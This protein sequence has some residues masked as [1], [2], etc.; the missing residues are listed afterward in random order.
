MYQKNSGERA[1]ATRSE[2]DYG[3]R[4]EGCEGEGD[5][6]RRIRGRP[7]FLAKADSSSERASTKIHSP[8][9]DSSKRVFMLQG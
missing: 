6:K 4:K 9:I 7:L 2:R 5:K 8:C 3:E 1:V